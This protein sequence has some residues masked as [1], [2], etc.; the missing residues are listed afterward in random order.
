MQLGFMS[1][2]GT[3]DA[4]FVVQKMQEEYRNK[5]IKL[6]TCVLWMLKRHLIEY[7]KW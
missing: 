5:K 1:G 7:Q 4:L 6:C 2:I 3:T